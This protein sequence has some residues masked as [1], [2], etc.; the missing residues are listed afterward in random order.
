MTGTTPGGVTDSSF[1]SAEML[2]VSSSSA[3]LS[4]IAAPTP[5]SSRSRPCSDSRAT[6]SGVSRSVFAALR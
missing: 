1:S 2:P 6:D 3:T 4:A 5:G